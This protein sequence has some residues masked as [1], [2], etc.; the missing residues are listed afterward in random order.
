[1]L[2]G[3]FPKLCKLVETC[4]VF[5]G[6]ASVESSHSGPFS[7]T[8]VNTYHTLINVIT[9]TFRLYDTWKLAR[10]ISVVFLGNYA[11]MKVIFYLH[12]C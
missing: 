3:D 6:T 7:H 11:S 4:E 8:L 1:M 2:T 10:H 5:R 9:L 12:T